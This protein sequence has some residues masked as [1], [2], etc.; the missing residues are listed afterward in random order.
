M[1]KEVEPGKEGATPE[2]TYNFPWQGTTEISTESPCTNETAPSYN[3]MSPAD[4]YSSE[5]EVNGLNDLIVPDFENAFLFEAEFGPLNLPD[6]QNEVGLFEG[7]VTPPLQEQINFMEDSHDISYTTPARALDLPSQSSHLMSPELTDTNSPGSGYGVTTPITR[8]RLLGGGAMSRLS[9]QST[10]TEPNH[11]VYQRTPALTTS[12]VEASPEPASGLD[13]GHTASPVVRIESYSRGDSPARAV[14]LMLCN[15]SKRSRMSRSS[16]YLAAPDDDS[17]DEDNHGSNSDDQSRTL[18]GLNLSATLDE[19]DRVSDRRSGFDPV[20]RLQMTDVIVPNFKDQ[21]EI[22]ELDVRKAGIRDWLSKSGPLNESHAVTEGSLGIRKYKTSNSRRRARSAAENYDLQVDSLGI[23]SRKLVEAES[24]IPG[25]GLL[26]NEDSGE[27]EDEDAC[28]APQTPQSSKERIEEEIET[29]GGYFANPDRDSK[30][31]L[32]AS[33]WAD[34]IFFPSK[35]GSR[36]QPATSNEAIAF[37]WK[38]AADIE[39]ISRRA[40]CGTS[41]RRLSENDLDRILGPEGLLS[42]FSISREKIM[43]KIDSH[44]SSLASRI[45]LKR[46]TS[47]MKRK[48]SEPTRQQSEQTLPPNNGRKESLRGRKE[49]L[50]GRKDS[51]Q[52]QK[53][54]VVSRPENPTVSSSLRRIPSLNKRPKSPSL[55]TSSTMV[56]M[57]SHIASLGGNGSI[58]STTTSPPAGAWNTA[59]TLMRRKSRGDSNRPSMSN[60]TDSGLAA[61]WTKQG[62]PPLPTLA[63]PP[64]E[65]NISAPFEAQADDDE[66]AET[67]ELPNEHGISM[68]FTPR[69]DKI[70][71]TKEGFKTNVQALNPRLAPYLV[72]R[73]GQEQLRRFKKLIEFRVGH[74]K[75]IQNGVCSSGKHCIELGGEPSY[76]GSKAS[77]KEP[78]LSHTGFSVTGMER[79]DLDANA[80]PEGIVTAAQFPPGVPLPPVHRLPAEF[81][82]PLCFT[83]K[84]IQKPSDWSKHVHEDLQPFTC[85]FPDCSEPKSFK[86]KADWVRHENERHRQL[87]WWN[88]SM[89]E[90]LHKCYRRDNFVQHLVREH[91]LTEPNAKCA[92]SNKPAVRGPAK[93]KPR[94]KGEVENHTSEDD[95]LDLVA[96]CRHETPKQPKG[97]PCRF[98]GNVCNSWKKLTVHLAKHM[99]QISIPVLDLVR[100]LDVTPETIIS[101][102]EQTLPS[103]TTNTPPATEDQSISRGSASIS[104]LYDMTMNMSNIKQELPS[105]FT[106]LQP[107]AMFHSPNENQS[108]GALQWGQPNSQ[109]S[110]AQA[111]GPLAYVQGLDTDYPPSYT[112]YNSPE[113]APFQVGSSQL[114]H[115]HTLPRSSAGPIYTGLRG[116]VSYTRQASYPENRS[117][118]MGMSQ[119]PTSSAPLEG[120]FFASQNDFST[121]QAPQLPAHMAIPPHLGLRSDIGFPPGQGNLN[122]IYQ[123]QSQQQYYPYPM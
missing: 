67:E 106:P 118:P 120:P 61:L 49:S 105:S 89:P 9:S 2:F 4:T 13:N 39:T 100:Q 56:A 65:L 44:G 66:A 79:S 78:E 12:S 93:S 23:N 87:E 38:Q 45:L 27:E 113:A 29:A 28:E 84:K 76:L 69:K 20:M 32:E 110:Q 54:S 86:R 71:P 112:A 42:R 108:P 75:A 17:S 3:G 97:E 21:D 40:T 101:P 11:S 96:S 102:I 5:Y 95:V 72:E 57:S 51:L 80:L 83:I 104:P 63:S 30:P 85:T 115:M 90:C 88:C 82:C 43:E 98:C 109:S 59:R 47:H 70:T 26:L 64:E 15:S 52:D 121:T 111:G 22:N 81:E 60:A 119:L 46:S 50:H 103:H 74:I 35:V 8:V 68:D 53:E 123:D 18:L 91:K 92:K 7:P 24:Q 94:A 1:Y 19:H 77:K 41:V 58:S 73:L 117:F 48:S 10:A 16:S 31:P 107:T 14:G 55:N 37:Y 99:E 114:N 122:A 25:P 116:Q 34:P 33:P 36:D 6:D 62:G